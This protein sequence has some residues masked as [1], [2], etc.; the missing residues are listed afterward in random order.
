[1][2]GCGLVGNTSAT[3]ETVPSSSRNRMAIENFEF[4]GIN[5]DWSS[6]GAWSVTASSLPHGRLFPNT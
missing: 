6:N 2:R 5:S 4:V 1:M 3:P